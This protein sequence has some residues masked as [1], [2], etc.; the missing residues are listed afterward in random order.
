MRDDK[1]QQFKVDWIDGGREPSHPPD[2]NYPDGVDLS[3]VA[4]P[5]KRSCKVELPYPAKRC[6]YYR[7]ECRACGLKVGITTAGRPDDPRSA[8]FHCLVTKP[9]VVIATPAQVIT[10]IFS[11]LTKEQ[12]RALV[13]YFEGKYCMGGA[14]RPG[15]WRELKPGERCYCWDDN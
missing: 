11:E 8:T 5:A 1:N 14:G 15:C 3:V 10:Q 9:P 6:G 2:P 4:D 7:V 13:A 12:R